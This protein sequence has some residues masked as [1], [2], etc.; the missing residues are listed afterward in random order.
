MRRTDVKR[1]RKVFYRFLAVLMIFCVVMSAGVYSFAETGVE[2]ARNSVVRVFLPVNGTAVVTGTG[3]VVGTDENDT[4]IVV[5][6]NHVV[7][8]NPNAVY[9]TE[10]NADSAISA[11]V[12]YRDVQKDIA[13]L[14][15]ERSLENRVPIPL[16]SPQEMTITDDVCCLGFPGL[17]DVFRTTEGSIRKS[18]ISLPQKAR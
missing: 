17:S 1:E 4:R 15:L 11:A 3:F 16:K 7:E 13:I 14:R 2:R 10:H 12:I 5:T 9:V 8:E 6:N 18:M